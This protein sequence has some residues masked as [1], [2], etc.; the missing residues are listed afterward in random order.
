[1][2]LLMLIAKLYIAL[3]LSIDK[4]T[5]TYSK[6][7]FL[8]HKQIRKQLKKYLQHLY[9]YIRATFYAEILIINETYKTKR[10]DLKRFLSVL[11]FV[12]FA[13]FL[14]FSALP[15]QEKILS[16]A[17]GADDDAVYTCNE[18]T[19][20][21]TNNCDVSAYGN[22]G[23]CTDCTYWALGTSGDC[24]GDATCATTTCCGDDTGEYAISESSGTDAPIG[25]NDAVLSCCDVSTDCNFNGFCTTTGIVS[26]PA[27]PSKAYCSSGTWLGGDAS[28]TACSAIAGL[29]LWN[30]GGETA[31][32]TCCGDDSSESNSTRLVDEA[33]MENSYADDASDDACCLASTDCIASSTCYDTG[34]SSGDADS[35]GDNDY[36]DSG[37]WKDCNTK[38]DCSGA[39][40]CSQTTNDCI[41]P[42]GYILIRNLGTT[43]IEQ[44]NQEF[45]S[46]IT[47]YLQLNYSENA[48]ECRYANND[49]PYTKPAEDS[50][51]WTEWEPCVISRLWQLTSGSGNKTVYYQIN[52]THFKNS[53]LNDSIYYNHTGSGLDTTNPN[54]ATIDDG[55]YSNNNASITVSWTG[56][57][58]PESTVLGIPLSYTYTIFL[59]NGTI[60]ATGATT[61]TSV[62]STGHNIP[63]NTT[64]YTN[65]TVINSAGLTNTSMSDGLVIDLEKPYILTLEGSFYNVS[66]SFYKNLKA[67]SE[68]T[69]VYAN[70]VNLTWQGW[71]DLTNATVA[72]SYLLTDNPNLQP[73]TIPEGTTGSFASHLTKIF[74]SLS[75]DKYYFYISA[76]DKAGN[77]A[78]P[79]SINFSLDSTPG[80]KP[81]VESITSNTVNLTV[82]WLASTD[83]ESGINNYRVNLTYSNGSVIDSALTNTTS[84]LS[85]TFTG[86]STGDYNATVGSLNGVGIWRWSNQD[87]DT[88]DFIPPTIIATPNRTVATTSPIIKAWTDETAV[89][90]YNSSSSE[91]EFIYTNTTYHETR[92]TGLSNG[93]YRYRITCT[94]LS[95]NS[96]SVEINF[97]IDTAKG[98]DTIT[99]PSSLNTYSSLLT[100]FSV[101]V[102]GSSSDISK[103]KETEILYIN[104]IAQEHS[105]FARGDGSFN[106]SFIAPKNI[107][108][109]NL[110]LAIEN[111]DINITLNVNSLYL[112]ATYVDGTVSNIRS[113]DHII[114]YQPASARRFGLASN[115]HTDYLILS[116]SSTNI[117]A[118][119]I[120]L[121][122]ELFIFSTKSSSL[123]N[124]KEKLLYDNN[125]HEKINPSF[126]YKL[127]DTYLIDFVLRYNRFDI[128]T[129]SGNTLAKGNNNFLVR[130]DLNSQGEKQIIFRKT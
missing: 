8:L 12:I 1:M 15:G 53:T 130:N 70:K 68:D 126:G 100:T 104:N 43:G 98:T 40:I 110:R 96:G 66:S 25:Y 13:Y 102:Q 91:I 46:M 54:A 99:G 107:G 62:T 69:W 55:D 86:L 38:A 4:L 77:W 7:L 45:T 49:D 97:T 19:C 89:C 59:A 118:S 39:Q 67:Q 35:D 72:Y 74:T 10:A 116:S 80:S 93:P 82:T 16:C 75:S 122:N 61:S 47:V 14:L 41:N 94:D 83:S 33:V 48:S 29:N 117:S 121:G 2:K 18:G 81:I 76:K 95:G 106:V 3:V 123:I 108:A 88:L 85:Y 30:L 112:E 63:H 105:F 44:S 6:K 113:T 52:F 109:Y 84:T 5:D 28:S 78:V 9:K 124:A 119:G 65:I 24:T 21:G 73:D 87:G 103:I 37:T 115:E 92:I 79:A 60:I 26:S 56:A 120:T 101:D 34:S 27:I 23:D 57:S 36:C 42:D 22:S 114:Y 58:D 127:D 128:E 51:S 125:F 64:V 32:T 90:T 20:L 17:L 31:S 11:I 129:E 50:S 111:Y 71:D